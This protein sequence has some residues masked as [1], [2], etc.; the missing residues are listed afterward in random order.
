ERIA[1]WTVGI[2]LPRAQESAARRGGGARHSRAR[3]GR[4]AVR[5]A[6]RP[7]ATG[8]TAARRRSSSPGRTLAARRGVPRAADKGGVVSGACRPRIARARAPRL[9]ADLYR[10]VAALLF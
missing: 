5:S 4:C 6:R 1:W 10:P 2:G 3:D 9:R 7:L 8:E